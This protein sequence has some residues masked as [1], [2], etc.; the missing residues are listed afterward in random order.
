MVKCLGKLS[1]DTLEDTKKANDPSK[2][3]ESQGIL[4]GNAIKTWIHTWS[5]LVYDGPFTPVESMERRISGLLTKWFAV[6]KGFVKQGSK[7]TF[8]A[9]GNL[10]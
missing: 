1:G 4:L 7:A 10:G 2:R 3:S 5:S 8:T 6:H 9:D